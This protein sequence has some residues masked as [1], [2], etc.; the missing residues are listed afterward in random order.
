MA[1]STSR[2][3]NSGK[4]LTPVAEAATGEVANPVTSKNSSKDTQKSTRKVKKTAAKGK[5]TMAKQVNTMTATEKKTAAK[6]AS[7]LKQGKKATT[8]TKAATKT[9]KTAKKATKKKTQRKAKPLYTTDA[10]RAYLHEI[11]RVPLLSHEDEIV[12]GKQVQKMMALLEIKETLTAEL[13]D[14]DEANVG[15]LGPLC[16]RNFCVRNF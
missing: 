4:S 15:G 9:K 11:G 7:K 5:K 3:A 13:P 1:Q 16:V 2:T 12:L 8:K 10:V 6:K 14:V